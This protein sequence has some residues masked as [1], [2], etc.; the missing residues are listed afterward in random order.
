M[1]EAARLAYL[2]AIGV[3]N[4]VSRQPLPR[5]RASTVLKLIPADLSPA[6]PST[7]AK[8]A[9]LAGGIENTVD[10]LKH[11]IGAETEA[12]VDRDS[13]V[14]AKRP[15]PFVGGQSPH[16]RFALILVRFGGILWIDT[17]SDGRGVDREYLRLIVSIGRALGKEGSQPD[18]EVFEW[19]L[20][21]NRQVN[22]GEDAAREAIEEFVTR[23]LKDNGISRVVILGKQPVKLDG[24]SVDTT[25]SSVSGWDM[26]KNSAHKRTA[27][28]E[29]KHLRLQ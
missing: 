9:L 23:Q 12:S 25:S 5:A 3:D 7:V 16:L 13:G 20:V 14:L 17:L 18:Y 10:Q 1:N 27:W 11:S 2:Q 4:F 26:L 22:Q 8:A 28:Q 15:K 6:P 21:R 24:H 19:P 29:L